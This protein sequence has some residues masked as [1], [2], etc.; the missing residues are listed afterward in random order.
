MNEEEIIERVNKFTNITVL[1]GKTYAMTA[2]DL[3]KYQQVFKGLLDLYQQEKEKNIKLDREI[4]K[5][6]WIKVKENG[7]IEPLFYISKDKIKEKM[8][9]IENE[10]E[11]CSY[12]HIL[13]EERKPLVNGTKYCLKL[14][15]YDVLKSLLEE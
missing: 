5:R 15:C 13:C 14:E 4:K 2:D 6:Q 9:I 8:E 1:Y 12:N 3:T 7:E 10:C 11:T